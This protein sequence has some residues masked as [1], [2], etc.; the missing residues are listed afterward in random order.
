MW[1]SRKYSVKRHIA[2][3]HYGNAD[4]VSYIYYVVGRQTGLYRASSIPKYEN[5]ARTSLDIF[6]EEFWKE[7]AR[8]AARGN[9][10][11]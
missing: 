11:I 7:K 3:R 10:I 9:R 2:N 4:L 1:S 5:K 6:I 8:L